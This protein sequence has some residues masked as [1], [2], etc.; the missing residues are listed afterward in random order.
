MKRWINIADHGDAVTLIKELAP[1]F[2]TRIQDQKVN[3]GAHTPDVRPY[4]TARET[5]LALAEVPG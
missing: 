3:N 4:L 2:G 5:G 1:E